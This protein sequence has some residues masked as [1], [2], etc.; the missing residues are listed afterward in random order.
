M[1]LG[2]RSAGLFHSPNE[3]LHV[4][5]LLAERWDFVSLHFA[6]NG[7]F[8]SIDREPLLG[9]ALG[10]EPLPAAPL[11]EAAEDRELLRLCSLYFEAKFSMA[12]I[13]LLAGE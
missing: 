12:T 4:G 2:V 8:L 1:A 3:V 6:Q 7:Q 11:D 5:E 13:D 10:E 9:Q